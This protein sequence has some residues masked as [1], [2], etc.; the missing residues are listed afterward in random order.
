MEKTFRI[1]KNSTILQNN[2]TPIVMQN[3]VG[4]TTL[5]QLQTDLSVATQQLN[6]TQEIVNLINTKIGLVNNAGDNDF[7]VLP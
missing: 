5:T 4:S 1:L 2:G 6:R 3:Q 7:I